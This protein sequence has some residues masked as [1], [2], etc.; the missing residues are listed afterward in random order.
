M[1]AILSKPA[2]DAINGEPIESHPFRVAVDSFWETQTLCHCVTKADAKK[3]FDYYLSRR[4]HNEKTSLCIY[5][6]TLF[7]ATQKHTTTQHI[8]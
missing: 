6:D 1:E 2:I 8:T 4:T 7:L 3:V 5:D